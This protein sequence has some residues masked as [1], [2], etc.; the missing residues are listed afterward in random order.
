[1]VILDC[2]ITGP[3]SPACEELV[4]R[5]ESRSIGGLET[6]YRSS[7]RKA[8]HVRFNTAISQTNTAPT[9]SENTQTSALPDTYRGAQR[10]F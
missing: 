7:N 1:M 8:E 10:D 2:F 6:P 5:L 4:H 9:A 3:P